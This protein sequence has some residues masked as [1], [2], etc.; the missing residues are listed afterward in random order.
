MQLYKSY[1]FRTKD[2]IIHEVWD[3]VKDQKLANVA[4]DSGVTLNTLHSWFFGATQRPQAATIRAVLRSIGHDL[5][6]SQG[7]RNVDTNPPPIVKPKEVQKLNWKRGQ[8]WKRRLP[9]VVQK[10][11]A[12]R[13][14]T[15]ADR[16]SR[17]RE[18]QGG[19]GAGA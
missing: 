17:T 10:K 1:A 3:V 4:A 2:P 18:D 7:V 14:A 5:N 12:K 15:S 13:G 11:E 16:R 6:V 19:N 9:V 8:G